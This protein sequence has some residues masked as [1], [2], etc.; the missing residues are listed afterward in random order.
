MP[1]VLIQQ[2]EIDAD[3]EPSSK[4]WMNRNVLDDFVVQRPSNIGLQLIGEYSLGGHAFAKVESK[5]WK[6]RL[7]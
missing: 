6:R 3:C 7:T 4:S 2:L 5:Y 1:D